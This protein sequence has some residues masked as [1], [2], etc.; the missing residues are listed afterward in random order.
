MRK[1]VLLLISI[2]TLSYVCQA[3][4]S[5]YTLTGKTQGIL[6]GTVLY[7]EDPATRTYMDSAVVKDNK[8]SFKGI[9]EEDYFV[10]V[11]IAGQD[12]SDYRLVWLEKNDITLDASES[13]LSGSKITGSKIDIIDQQLQKELEGMS[14][15]QI[16][17]K[18]EDHIRENPSSIYSVHLLSVYYSV[19]GREKTEELF[20]KFPDKLKSTSY[21]KAVAFY[22]EKNKEPKIGED[23][24]DFEMMDI[25][26]KPRKVSELKGK[27]FL[28]EF[29]ASWC[30]PCRAEN[31]TLVKTYN[32]FHDKGFE[33]I[34]VSMDNSK[35]DWEEAVESDGLPWIHISDL[36]GGNSE[37][38]LIYGISSI[39]D[40]FLIDE[41]GKVIAKGLRGEMLKEKLSEVMKK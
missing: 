41:N 27:V 30:G 33:I 17:R 10:A 29:W 21:G 26:G 13:N 7:L 20:A 19:W 18:V 3:Q 32:E 25:N 22:L 12:Y 11:L 2:I 40:N 34:A 31:P 37:A 5:N 38:G 9:L 8:F 23:F 14:Y 6:D 4:E 39:P 28:L 36:K 35:T 15:N 16:I 24:V 1:Q